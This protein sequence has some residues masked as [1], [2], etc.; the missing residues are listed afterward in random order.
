[1]Y[2]IRKGGM[3]KEALN[4]RNHRRHLQLVNSESKLYEWNNLDN[5]HQDNRNLKYYA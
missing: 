2:E 4:H 3:G 1:M 5:L